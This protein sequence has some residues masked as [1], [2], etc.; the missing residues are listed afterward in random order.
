M[1]QWDQ[2]TPLPNSGSLQP[3]KVLKTLRSAGMPENK[4]QSAVIEAAAAGVTHS[5]FPCD[6][7]TKVAV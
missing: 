5:G 1:W 4:L 6:M 7:L 2:N 3:A